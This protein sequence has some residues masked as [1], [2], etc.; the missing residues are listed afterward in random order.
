MVAANKKPAGKGGLSEGHDES[1]NQNIDKL[2]ENV[3]VPVPAWMVTKAARIVREHDEQLHGV[4]G[5]FKELMPEYKPDLAR[6]FGECLYAAAIILIAGLQ[7]YPGLKGKLPQDFIEALV[8]APSGAGLTK[9]EKFALIVADY[10]AR[11][12]A[13]GDS[14]A[15]DTL[16]D[17]AR[18][19]IES[20]ASLLEGGDE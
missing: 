20:L 4:T 2:S 9:R 14:T 17:F 12:A 1:S 8:Q 7:S 16:E 6:S 3:K 10:D 11:E 13:G 15:G 18:C 5:I 19:R